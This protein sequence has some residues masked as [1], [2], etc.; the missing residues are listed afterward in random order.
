MRVVI[1]FLLLLAACSD[2]KVQWSEV[3]YSAPPRPTNVSIAAMSPLRGACPVS[4]R[5]TRAGK[6]I[7]AAWWSIR[8]DSSG[9]LLVAQSNDSGKS[10]NAPVIAD[11]TDQS[12]RGCAR[13][14]PAIAA[15]S[16]SGYVHVAYF[17]EPMRGRGIFF[18]HS[19]D[20]GRTFHSPVPIVFGDN[21]AFV[22]VASDGDRVAVAYD[23]PNSGQP[24]IGIALSNTM[25]H[26]FKPGDPIS[27]ASERAK[28]P[29]VELSGDR[30]RVWWSDYSDDPRI[31]AART[32]YREGIWK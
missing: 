4:V 26:I 6:A 2:Q 25:G 24:S 8:D 28:Q 13:P 22:A 1:A 15:D 31:S 7:L 16:A 29:T 20:S 27:S 14:A 21:P 30:I 5:A 11:S 19:M 9:V 32:A 18:A 12:V 17:A 10:W 3:S 23:D